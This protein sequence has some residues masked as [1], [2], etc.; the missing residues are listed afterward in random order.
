VKKNE[1]VHLSPQFRQTMD[2][3][4][5]DEQLIEYFRQEPFSLCS[6]DPKDLCA[7]GSVVICTP[8]NDEELTSQR[9]EKRDYVV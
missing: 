3:P 9:A 1:D 2:Y 8:G 4:Y 7:A 5:V 6:P